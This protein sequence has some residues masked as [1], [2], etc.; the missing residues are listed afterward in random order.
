[1]EGFWVQGFRNGTIWDQIGENGKGHGNSYVMFCYCRDYIGEGL[2]FRVQG[3]GEWSNM[4][5]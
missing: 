2:G 3:A 5:F 4:G 1:M